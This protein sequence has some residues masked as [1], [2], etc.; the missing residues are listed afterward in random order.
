MHLLEKNVMGKDVYITK[1]PDSTISFPQWHNTQDKFWP[2]GR[3]HRDHDKNNPP[4]KV[5][6]IGSICVL[7]K[8]I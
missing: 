8:L 7:I 1:T 4:L 6:S 5:C 3:N 2:G